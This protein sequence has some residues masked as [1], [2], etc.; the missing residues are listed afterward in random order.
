M[1]R[2]ID[3][4]EHEDAELF[5]AESYNF[6]A[7]RF[8]VAPGNYTVKLYLKAGFERGFKPGNFV[9]SVEVEG[10]RVLDDFDVVAACG[11]DFTQVAIKT[12]ENVNVQ[13]GQLEIRFLTEDGR[14]PSVKLANAI[15][16]IR[17]GE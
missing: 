6:D 7:Y 8:V 2:K 3:G 10:R 11:T 15:E 4:V 13:D 12:F 17:Q 5:I 14:S 9:F 16:V 1:N